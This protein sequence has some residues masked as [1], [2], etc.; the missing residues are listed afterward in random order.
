MYFL[1]NLDFLRAA[2]MM[3]GRYAE[4]KR[5]ADDLAEK[6]RPMSKQ[7]PMFEGLLAAP[8][9]VLVRFRKWDEVLKVPE[10]ET[11][12]PLTHVFWHYARGLAYASRRD[13]LRSQAERDAFLSES[14]KIP[15]DAVIGLN[16]APTV[17]GIAKG[18]LDAG[19]LSARGEAK[20]AV[21]SLKEAV[22]LQDSLNYDEPADWYYPVRETLGGALLR[23]KRYAEAGKVFR[24]DLKRNPHNGRSLFGLWQ[25][26]KAR[27]RTAEADKVR[28]EF[29][30][31]WKGAD[32][33][34]RMED[35]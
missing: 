18:V 3:E 14:R 8:T 11:D 5:A 32:T 13:H 6:G 2:T 27:G 24:A 29:E 9:L 7:M 15:A 33:P 10:P 17:M 26:L 22:A 28:R 20:A 34:L 19:I 31:A 25:S 21:T 23:D 30:H 16:A 4:A 1:H 35:L 12:L